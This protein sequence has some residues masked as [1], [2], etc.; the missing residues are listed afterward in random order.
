MVTNLSNEIPLC[1][2][3]DPDTLKSPA[4]PITPI[5][6]ERP[7]SEPLTTARQMAVD[8]PT[9]VTGRTDSFIDDLIRI[10][11][12]TAKNR[13]TQPHAVPL[14][15]HATSQPHLGAG[16]PI[17]GRGLLSGPKLIAV[18][19]PAEV[20]IVLGW[21][22]NTRSLTIL[23]PHDKFEAWSEDLRLIVQVGKASFGELESTVG[24][25]NHAAYV[26]PLARHF[27]NRIR[28]RIKDRRHKNQ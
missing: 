5:R 12:D 9:T 26:I 14:A 20:Q 19:T 1:D 21:D 7:A 23:L 28:L 24:R 11:L 25:L 3:W 8:V 27:L 4:Q 16:K 10:F 6:I 22:L 17:Q 18:G 2:N 13:R 15:I